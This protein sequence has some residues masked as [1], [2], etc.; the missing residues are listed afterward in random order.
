MTNNRRRTWGKASGASIAATA[1]LAAAGVLPGRAMAQDAVCVDAVTGGNMGATSGAGFEVAC[2]NGAVASAPDA[3]AVGRS[4]VAR[5]TNA[6][7]IG[8]NANSNAQNG[9]AIGYGAYNQGTQP[10]ITT[11]GAVAIGGLAHTFTSY[12][13]AVGYAADARAPGA[14]A[15]GASAK[16]TN[17][18]AIAIGA[19]PSGNGAMAVGGGSIAIGS[20]GGGALLGTPALAN[21]ARAIAIGQNTVAFAGSVALG[22]TATA[23]ATGVTGNVAIGNGATATTSAGGVALGSGSVSD[24]ALA[25][26]QGTIP[27]GANFVVP[28]NTTDRTLLGAVSVGNATSYRQITNVADGTQQNDAVTVRQLSGALQSFAVTPTMYFHANSSAA[29]SLAVGMDSVAI[30]PQTVVNANN[31]IGMGNGA[32]VQASAPGGIAIGQASTSGAADAVALGTQASAN[33]VQGV[34]LGAGSTVTQAGGVALGAGSVANTASGVA[35]YVPPTATAEQRRAIGATTSTLAA[36]SVGDAANGQFRQITGVAAGTVDSDAV[37]VSQLKAVQGQVTQVDQGTVKYDTHTD[38]TTNYNSV[39]MGG[40]NSTGAVTVHN[41]AA[42]VEGTDAVNVNQ[43]NAGLE[44]NRQY[45]DQRFNQLSG[46]LRKS[47][48][49]AS[50]GTAAAIAMANLPQAYIPGKSM[51]S[52]GV[53]GYDGEA[54]IALGVSKLSDNGR[55]VVKFSATGNSRS[56]F[57]VGA[58]AGFHW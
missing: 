2:G 33:A 27:A 10:A 45:T 4:A 7:A 38:G 12:T 32:T 25:G 21:G 16:S 37:N 55:W 23:G 46:D 51:V 14:L 34:A 42:G 1:L 48:K 52:A 53:G 9:V 15:I 20:G 19:A 31:G 28:Y 30:G 8:S 47:A 36:V 29:D 18:Y 56:K 40:S 6:V 58:G 5:R 26:V 49:R 41:V 54:G 24:R 17:A 3:V 35:A 50:A 39:T 43:L 11:M 44:G 22:Y 57:G 13:T